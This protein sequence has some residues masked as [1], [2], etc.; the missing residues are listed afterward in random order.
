MSVYDFASI[1][2]LAPNCTLPASVG[3]DFNDTLQTAGFE[4]ISSLGNIK[5]L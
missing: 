5:L 3:I 4:I 2:K 1:K